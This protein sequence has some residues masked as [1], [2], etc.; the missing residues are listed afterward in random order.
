MKQGGP[1]SPTGFNKQINPMIVILNES[2]KLF[3]IRA[4]NGGAI[5]YADD[6]TSI[7]ESAEKMHEVIKL[8]VDFCAKYDI[9]I[10]EK[11][12]KW[13]KQGERVRETIDGKPLVP[14]ALET[15]M[16]KINGQLIEKVDR[17]KLLGS[18]AMAN[19]KAKEHVKKRTQAMHK[20]HMPQFKN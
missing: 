2:G 12:T 17:F 15:E 1:F 6:T 4:V 8:M 16:F 5:V 20:Q 7:T 13:M 14:P 9:I 19:G 3:T 10:N 18:C 11:K